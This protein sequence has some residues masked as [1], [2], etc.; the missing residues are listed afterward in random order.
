VVL[1]IGEI[2]ADIFPAY[3]RFGG[4]PFNFAYHLKQFGIP[5]TFVSRIGEDALGTEILNLLETD[6]FD[7]RH[8]QVDPDHPT[9]RVTVTPDGSGGHSFDIHPDVAYDHIEFTE[10][11]GDL[12]QKE[13]LELIYFGTL[14]Q[15]TPSAFLRTQA[16]LAKKPPHARCFYDINLRPNCFNHEIIKSSLKHADILKLNDDELDYIRK[17]FDSSLPHEPFVEW[18]MTYYNIELLALT[19]GGN[20][21]EIFTPADHYTIEVP[22]ID[23]IVDTVGAGDAYSAILAIGCLNDWPPQRILSIGT[24]FASDICRIKGAVPDN[25][26]FYKS[27]KQQLTGDENG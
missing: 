25:P 15:R 18:L 14:M 26:D 7:A 8:I 21:S 16:F 13:P 9:G 10:T 24:A 11:P 17:M 6:G 12:V 1:V 20:G 2:L 23:Q 19:R 27:Y 22:E 5:V 3:Q 4:A